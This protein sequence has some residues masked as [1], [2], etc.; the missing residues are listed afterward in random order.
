[1]ADRG[2]AGRTGVFDPQIAQ[3]FADEESANLR[4]SASSADHFFL[5]SSTT[6]LPARVPLSAR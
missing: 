5:E 2:E 3:I 1:V 6:G 4:K